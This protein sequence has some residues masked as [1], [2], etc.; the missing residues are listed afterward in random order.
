M[1]GGLVEHPFESRSSRLDK[2]AVEAAN[3]LLFWGRWHDD[4]RIVVVEGIV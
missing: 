2:I 4:A 3:S 1:G